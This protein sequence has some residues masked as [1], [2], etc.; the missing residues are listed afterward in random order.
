MKNCINCINKAGC[1][2]YIKLKEGLDHDSFNKE[3]YVKNHVAIYKAIALNC[4]NFN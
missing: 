2:I 4:K 1:N 3:P